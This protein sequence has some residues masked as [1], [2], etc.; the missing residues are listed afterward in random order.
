MAGLV[1]PV[2]EWAAL[3][4]LVHRYTARVDERDFAGVAQ[5]FGGDGVLVLPDPPHDFGPVREHP[6]PEG[7]AA[8]LSVLDDVPLTAHGITGVVFDPG[9]NPAARGRITCVAHHVGPR[10]G[11]FADAVWH[12]HYLDRYAKTGGGW[13][14]ARREA[15]LDLL[16]TREVRATRLGR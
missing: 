1:I 13:R 10:D 12:R 9:G 3:H 8:A 4:D 5:L 11:R 7:V 15:H 16:D 6:S 14:F 2:A